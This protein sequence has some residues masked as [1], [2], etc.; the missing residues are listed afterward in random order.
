MAVDQSAPARQDRTSTGLALP[1]TFAQWVTVDVAPTSGNYQ[2]TWYIG[3]AVYSNFVG[4]GVADDGTIGVFDNDFANGA[5][6][7]TDAI[8]LGE[9]YWLCVSIS[10]GA[11][12]VFRWRH[13]DDVA[14][15]TEP[16]ST[17]VGTFANNLLVVGSD[18]DSVSLNGKWSHAR[19]W[20][21]VLSESEMLAESL[22]SVPVVAAWGAWPG[23][24]LGTDL[25][26]NARVLTP[27]GTF[28]D[29]EPPPLAGPPAP[30]VVAAA[31]VTTDYTDSFATSSFTAHAG[32]L[33]VIDVIV[34]DDA[35]T[36]APDSV[37][38]ASITGATLVDSV[39]VAPDANRRRLARF[40]AE[41]TGTAGAV[42][43]GQPGSPTMT[44][45]AYAVKVY[46]PGTEIRAS[47][48]GS[49][50]G[51][52]LA[53]TLPTPGADAAVDVAWDL[54]VASGTTTLEAGYQQLGGTLQYSSPT[55]RLVDAWRGAG[56][57]SP[58]ATHGASVAWGGIGS[59]VGPAGSG[60]DPAEGVAT[61]V[62]I[63]SGTAL[64]A[65][66]SV[67]VSTG[68]VTAAGAAVGLR[69]SIGAAVG[70]VVVS[71]T[72][73]GDTANS[74]QASGQLTTSGTVAGS[75]P[76]TSSVAGQLTVS[77]S[78]VGEA[79]EPG[80]GAATGQITVT[81]TAVGDNGG[82]GIVS[83]C[84]VEPVP[85]PCRPVRSVVGLA[86]QYG[87]CDAVPTIGEDDADLTVLAGCD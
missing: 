15:T 8:T 66:D 14:L 12:L 69:D 86:G 49:G 67:A 13:E 60:E 80:Q 84:R 9:R 40:H 43:I 21:S 71:G 64:G 65:R 52:A 44:G 72:A 77:G 85:S 6:A 34:S 73:V 17:F 81:G 57:T 4:F 39:E 30:A 75:R 27:S 37:T 19:M 10:A 7:S 3:T 41:G 28:V 23:D 35:A 18:P 47:A 20:T 63:T 24:A 48:Q 56:D 33:V 1:I 50:T 46:A 5:R 31:A 70:Q 78:A 82:E 11:V 74:G 29:V 25:S 87:H 22:S 26:G 59:E 55:T 38:G 54:P 62:T 45:R 36:S 53:V 32:S 68:Q 42:T 61:G 79:A 51:T 83:G 16:A 76:G 2:N 58:T